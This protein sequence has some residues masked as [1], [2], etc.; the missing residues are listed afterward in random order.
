MP[1]IGSL[2]VNQFR[3][4]ADVDITPHS[5]FNF[6]FGQNGAGKTSILESIYYL[7]VGRSFRTHLPQRLIQDNTDRFLIF[8]TLYNGTQ[9]IPLGVERDCHGD[10]CL[11]INGETASSWS[12]AAKRLPLCSLSAMSHRFLLDGPRVRRQ[13]LDW[14]MFHVEPSFFSIWQRLQRSLKQR[15]ASLKAKL[16]LGE[17]THWDK[18][19]VEDGERLHQLRQNVV[20][21]FKPLFTQMLQQFL[22]AYPLI[23]HYFR[24]W[25]EKYSLMEQLQINLKQDLQRGYTQAGPQRAD[26]RLTLRD[27]PAQDIL[28]QGQQKLVTYAL[29]FA[30]GLLLK[31]KTGISPIYLI[32]DLP[33]ELDAN[34]RDCVIDLVNCLESQVFISGIDPNE[35]RL[36]PHSTLFHVKHGKVAAL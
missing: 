14:L 8:I 10:R 16:P 26:F 13:F 25:S 19:L 15:N 17:I 1:Y 20:T 3:N 23:G 32:D 34:K 33:A 31:E 30:Q 27:L 18:M 21:E 35:I 36:P 22:P 7:S 11:R 28:S 5:Q 9:F 12:L 4:L 29:H 6:F 2:K 24:G